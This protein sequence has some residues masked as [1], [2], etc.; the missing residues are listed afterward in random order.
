MKKTILWFTS[1][2]AFKGYSDGFDTPEY[3]DKTFSCDSFEH[4]TISKLY[5]ILLKD[6]KINLKNEVII[7]QS[8][9]PINY[10]LP[11]GTLF[12]SDVK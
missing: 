5:S 11:S 9:L 8:D 3:I 4:Q 7:I 6:L 12:M 10:I 1:Q 2:W